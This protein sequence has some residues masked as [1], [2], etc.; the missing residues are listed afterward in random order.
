MRK[1][2]RQEKTYYGKFLISW[3]SHRSG[4][5]S[6][7]ISLS[8]YKI[9]H[10]KCQNRGS[11]ESARRAQILGVCSTDRHG[12]DTRIP[13]RR[14]VGPFRPN[15]IDAGPVR[16]SSIALVSPWAGERRIGLDFSP[17]A[18]NLPAIVQR[19]PMTCLHQ[20]ARGRPERDR[21]TAPAGQQRRQGAELLSPVL[22]PQR[23]QASVDTPSDWQST[24]GVLIW[25]FRGDVM[26]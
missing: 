10:S 11:P 23:P 9:R 22:F 12:S 21:S 19:L 2:G 25:P 13:R 4:F 1:P 14:S 16:R 20:P 17:T 3:L 24:L 18:R 7:R 5:G 26:R 6:R 15:R 8:D